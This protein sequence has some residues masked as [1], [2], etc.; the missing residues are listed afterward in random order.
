MS[1]NLKLTMVSNTN[2]PIDDIASAI[3][4]GTWDCVEKDVDLLQ[5]MKKINPDV[6]IIDD[7]KRFQSRDTTLD[8]SFVDSQ[9]MKVKTTGDKSGL[10]MPVLLYFPEE[11]EYEGTVFPADSYAILDR[12]H[13]TVIQVRCGIT[14]SN[15]YVVNYEMH[16]ESKMSNVRAL[17]NLL[18]LVW[19]ET[20]GTLIEHIKTEYHT[21]MDEKLVEKLDGYLT[22]A[23]NKVFLKRYPQI[24]STSLAN[25]A[26]SHNIVGGRRK[27]LK[28]WSDIELVLEQTK[29][30]KKKEYKDFIILSPRSAG[31]WNGEAS[32]NANWKS[33]DENNEKLLFIFYPNTMTQT[34]TKYQDRLRTRFEQYATH[35]NLEIKVIFLRSK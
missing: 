31:S 5:F 28:K 4:D 7:E 14:T 27:P 1:S 8:Y 26:S 17:A 2:V 12:N 24:N 35:Y 10:K 23:E 30:A 13:G 3:K 16:L 18:N 20:Q 25:F 21:K 33:M 6:Y 29:I 32:G 22:D 34:T 11:V 9:V 15:C 19:E